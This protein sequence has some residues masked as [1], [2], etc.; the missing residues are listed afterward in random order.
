[1]RFNLIVLFCL[2]HLACVCAA[3]DTAN[4]I[5]PTHAEVSYGPHPMNV[6]DFYQAEGEGR[7]TSVDLHSWWWLDRR[8]QEAGSCEVQTLS[9]QRHFLCGDQLPI[10]RCGPVTCSRSRCG[11]RNTIHTIQ[12]E[13]VEYKSESHCFDRWQALVL[14]LRCGFCCTMILRIQKRKIL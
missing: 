10:N 14:A 9:R 2:V 3:D 1:M 13:R 8:G 11:S 4:A 7:S 12:G 5:A 6:L